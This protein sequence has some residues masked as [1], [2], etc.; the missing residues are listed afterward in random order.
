MRR[1]FY[2]VLVCLAPSIGFSQE[3][4]AVW[5]VE[6]PK[7]G[8]VGLSFGPAD[9]PLL[10]F[11]CARGSGQVSASFAIAHRLAD[12]QVG[13]IWV[14]A[15]GVGAPWPATV[16]VASGGVFSAVRGRIDAS[17]TT[18]DSQAVGEISTAA[19]VVKVMAKTGV[20]AL[21]AISETLNPPAAKPGMV[22]KFLRVCK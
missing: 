18:G 1:T 19:P 9:G 17:P 21:S 10:R 15:V 5:S 22:R 13:G 11:A 16:R 4:G 14:D 3:V 20:V 7:V 2:F 8:E 6:T 12:H